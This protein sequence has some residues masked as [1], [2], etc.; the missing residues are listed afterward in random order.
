[1]G[2]RKVDL[3]LGSWHKV[4]NWQQLKESR[5]ANQTRHIQSLCKHPNFMSIYFHG[6][7]NQE[8][9]LEGAFSEI[10]KSSRSLVAYSIINPEQPQNCGRTRA[11]VIINF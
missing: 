2:T 3:N 7:F 5:Y 4:H 6:A 8:E 9:A 1:M 11:L 10:V